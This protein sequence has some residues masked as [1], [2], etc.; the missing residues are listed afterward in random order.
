MKNKKVMMLSIGSAVVLV[1]GQL[2]FNSSS[3][4]QVSQL[5]DKP[6]PND[7]IFIS[8]AE[9]DERS[10]KITPRASLVKVVNSQESILSEGVKYQMAD[11]SDAYAEN[12]RYPKYSKPLQASDWNLLNPRAFIPKAVPLNVHEGTTAEIVL[13]QY[14]VNRDDDLAVQVRIKSDTVDGLSPRSISVYISGDS[15]RDD[16]VSLTSLSSSEG[17]LTYSGEINSSS[18]NTLENSEVLIF[19]DIVFD[20]EE[21]AKVSAAFKLVGTDAKLTHLSDAYVEDVHL[22]IPAHF[23]IT[24]PGYYRV[25]ANLFDE[26]SQQPISHLNAAFLLTKREN[27]GLLKVHASTLR[28]KGS[29]GPYNLKNFNITRG[30]AKP[31]DKTGYGSSEETSFKIEGFDLSSYSYD[32]Y[33]DPKNQKRLEFLQKMAGIQ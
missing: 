2:L 21:R 18:F 27:T 32:A 19:A 12:I 23:D 1:A 25:Q 30:P 6:L 29:A 22:I 33:E 7:S 4:K 14:I 5:N 26:A 10:A 17:V 8:A 24:V 9:P 16:A 20:T 11:I 3:E 28:S 15:Q 31:G 13:S